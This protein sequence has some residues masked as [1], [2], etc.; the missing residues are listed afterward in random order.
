MR[1]I[2]LVDLKNQH[3]NIQP[4]VDQAIAEVLETATFINGPAVK[5]FK[6]N[7][8]T[9]LNNTPIVPCANGT[10]ALQIC[11][12][13]LGFK[14]GDEVVLPAFTYAA[15]AEVIALLGLVPKFVDVEESSFNIDVK[16]IEEV[17]TSKTKAIVPVHLFGQC[18]DMEPLLQI[19]DAKNIYVIE[20]LAQAIG[21][22]YKFSNGEEKFSGC[23]GDLG[24]TSF[25]PSK[26]LGCYGDGGAIVSKSSE[27]ADE[28]QMIANHGQSS[29][30]YHDVVGVNSRLD[31]IQAAIL[32][33]KLKHLGE[34]EKSRISAA[35]SYDERLKD[36]PQL[37]IPFR[38]PKSTHVFHQYTLTIHDGSREALKDELTQK[39]IPCKVYYPVPLHLQK[40]YNLSGYRE[41]SMPI[42]EKLSN[43]V[44]SLPM[45]TEL[46]EEQIDFITECINKFY[47]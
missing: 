32:D 33:V 43:S 8:S 14:R 42:S 20:D 17:I 40:A 35:N 22:K 10:D 31:S 2:E 12:M 19:T 37:S 28:C 26:N 41:G 15:T 23:M 4:E 39:G 21:S 46:D 13:A 38:F 16:K 18:V 9:Y 6:S 29:L 24:A 1:K 45:H 25:F 11:M 5:K 3:K 47:K 27:L 30:Y 44:L 36:I 34:Y 7:L